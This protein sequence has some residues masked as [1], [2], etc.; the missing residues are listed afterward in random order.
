VKYIHG[1]LSIIFGQKERNLSASSAVLLWRFLFRATPGLRSIPSAFSLDL[2]GFEKYTFLAG[3]GRNSLSFSTRLRVLQLV[4]RTIGIY[5][6][7]VRI[8]RGVPMYLTD[9]L[10]PANS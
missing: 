10:L 8:K 4:Y 9:L 6:S 1:F 7:N 3:S 5:T 2:C